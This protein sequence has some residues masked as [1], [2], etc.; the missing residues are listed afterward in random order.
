MP[1]AAASKHIA[2]PTKSLIPLPVCHTLPLGSWPA[3]AAGS[4]A[5]SQKALFRVAGTEVTRE[6]VIEEGQPFGTM[7]AA[8]TL[9]QGAFRPAWSGSVKCPKE[10]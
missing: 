6:V 3:E 5:P 2:P 9:A 4:P 8:G 10:L 7:A 1:S